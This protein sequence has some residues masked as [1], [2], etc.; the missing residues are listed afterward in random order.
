MVVFLCHPAVVDLK[1]KGRL[2]CLIFPLSCAFF[3]LAVDSYNPFLH[4]LDSHSPHSAPAPGPR[5]S[6]VWWVVD[7]A[8]LRITVECCIVEF[9]FVIGDRILQQTEIGGRET[10][11]FFSCHLVQRSPQRVFHCTPP[12]RRRRRRRRRHHHHRRRRHHHSH[13]TPFTSPVLT[14][15]ELRAKF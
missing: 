13:D 10:G 5:L 1:A 12:H 3:Y 11:L 14:S 9:F 15:V 7:P 6:V 4:F 2:Q 8:D